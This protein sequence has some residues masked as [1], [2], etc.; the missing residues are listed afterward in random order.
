MRPLRI[1]IAGLCLVIIVVGGAAAI[2]LRNQ[3]R[4]VQLVLSRI[5]AETGYNIVPV[6]ARV[7]FRS[8]LEVLLERPTVYLKGIEVARVD[9]LRAVIRYHTIFSTNGLPLYEIALDHPQVREPANLEGLTPHGFPKPDIT[10][11]TKLKWALDSISD[12]AQRIEIVNAALKDVDGTPLVD[13]LTLTAYRQHRGAGAWPWMVVVDAAWNHAPFDGAAMA[14][15]FKLG[16]APDDTSDLVVR[17]SMNFHGLEIAP[18]KGPYGI[19]NTGRVAGSLKFAMRHDGEVLGEADAKVE[20]LVLKGK[21]FNAPIALGDVL[22]QVAYKASI[23]RLEL[24]E[25]TVTQNGAPLLTGGIAIDQPYEDTR[26]AAMH[27]EGVRVALTQAASWMRL[28]RFVPASVND[29]AHRFTSGQVALNEASFNPST[30]VKDWSALTLRANLAAR[31][32]VTGIGFDVPANLKLPPIRRVE[33]AI[34]YAGGLLTLKQGSAGI[35][36]S[37]LTGVNAEVNL[38]R[39]TASISYKLRGKGVFDAGEL[40]PALNAIITAVEPDLAKRFAGISGTSAIDVDGAGK[41]TGMQWSIPTDYTLKVAPR[42]VEL[43]IKGAPSAIAITG[44]TMQLRPGVVQIDQ[45]IGELTTPR[46]GSATLNGTII[47]GRDPVFRDCVAEFREF[48][49]ETWLPLMLDP[50]E[51]SARGPVSGR[52]TAQTDTR[53]VAVPLITGRLTLGPGE[54]QFG[55]LR[56]PIAVQRTTV[57]LDGQGMKMAVPGGT[58]EGS[59]VNLTIT[60]TQFANPLLHL[61]ANVGMLDFEVMRFIRMPWSPKTPAEMFNLP[62]EGHIAAARGRFGKLPLSN[63]STDFERMNG[64][65]HVYN[66]AARS[67]GRPGETRSCGPLGFRPSQPSNS[68]HRHY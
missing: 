43:A 58:L 52:F 44:G 39:A 12:V 56:S 62:I 53:H 40:H 63:V 18:F 24:K 1:L 31:G 54:L 66:F 19:N 15:K 59:P 29:F 6:G 60:M 21:P 33:A 36:K 50:K 7:S 30:A 35:G 61:D 37:T 9:D 34:V 10:V 68:F 26:T 11:V 47:A 22:L 65:W 8:H 5:H 27:V 23:D 4:L 64:E 14:G 38:K 16:T 46:G 49:A 17:G 3:A 28:L 2:A 51:A 25:F 13:H 67:L 32:N 55:F 48:H 20:R 41:I 57:V 45:V 42:R